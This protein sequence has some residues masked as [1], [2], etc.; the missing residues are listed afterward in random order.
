MKNFVKLCITLY[1]CL[2][3]L[4]GCNTSDNN[5]K[6]NYNSNK[7]SISTSNPKKEVNIASF[8]T[9]I[10]DK[11]QNRMNNISLSCS[12]L[13]EYILK[14]GETFSFCDIIG[15]TSENTGFKEADMLDAN[16]KIFKG[17]SGGICQVSTTLYNALLQIPNIEIIERHTHSRR[18]YYIEKDKDVTVDSNSGL[19][20]KFKNNTGYDIKIY[21][22]N[23]NEEVTVKIMK[24]E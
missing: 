9:N 2:F 14:S 11:E 4:C 1:I 12:K 8:N 22:S 19:D 21:A 17:F 18:V 23:T 5:D 3:T 24:L 15:E 6:L 16:G 7:L 20:F 13:D 10:L